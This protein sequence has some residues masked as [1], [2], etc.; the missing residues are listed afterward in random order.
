M[1]TNTKRLLRRCWTSITAK[2]NMTEQDRLLADDILSAICTDE[3]EYT[4]IFKN[5]NEYKNNTD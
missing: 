2:P 5:L 3:P 4:I 1:E